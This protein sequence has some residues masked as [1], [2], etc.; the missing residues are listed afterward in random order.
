MYEVSGF[1]ESPD[2]APAGVS[3]LSMPIEAGKMQRATTTPAQSHA[4]N[5][6]RQKIS[7][8]IM[9]RAI[10]IGCAGLKRGLRCEGF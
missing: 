9:E 3:K 6:S 5:A 4:P 7:V 2:S 8:P 1:W 10:S